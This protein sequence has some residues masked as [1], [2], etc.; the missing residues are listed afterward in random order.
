[1]SNV[2]GHM[3]NVHKSVLLQEA[4]DGLDFH[5][6]DIFV[7]ATINGGGHSLEVARRFGKEVKIVG[8]DLDRN[9]LANAEKAL[10]DS[11]A[12][13]ALHESS[14]KNIVE[15]LNKETIAEVGKILFDLGLSSNQFENS[16]RGF[17]FQKDEPLLMTFKEKPDERDLTAYTIVNEWGEQSIADI[18]YGFGEERYSRR[19][20][21][22]IVE[23]R[24]VRPVKSTFELVEIIKQATPYTYH[25]GKIHF[26]TR[27]FQALRI[28]VNAETDALVAGLSGG[29][30]KL[31]AGGRMAVISF[32]SI[33]DRI[34]KRYFKELAREGKA[35]LINKKPIVPTREEIAENRRARSAKLRII[36]KL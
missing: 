18:I 9:A 34:V 16:G 12:D 5:K 13:Y 21:K 1:M 30:S 11:G 28:A 26:A 23:A 24:A 27:T 2:I 14:F 15:A 20:A 6:G 31:G 4:I 22:K 29:F 3:L 10:Q 35:I 25:K 17:S 33:E 36:Q 8:I 32:H 7:D 19:I